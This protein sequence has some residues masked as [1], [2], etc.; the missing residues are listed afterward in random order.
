MGWVGAIATS[1][2][3]A[4]AACTD[5]TT[6]S[7]QKPRAD[8]FAAIGTV[9]QLDKAGF[10]A[11]KNF[12]GK[13]VAVIRDPNKSDALIAINSLCPHQ[14]CTVKWESDASKFACPCHGSSFN[15]D[16][17]VATGP[18]AQNLQ[19]FTATI[20]ADMVYIKLT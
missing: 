13:K 17:S 16:G 1:L 12:N 2:P 20:E 3:L 18:A 5:S 6:Q 4:I 19:I 7:T 15:A 9:A 8:G 11:N 10:L 14:G